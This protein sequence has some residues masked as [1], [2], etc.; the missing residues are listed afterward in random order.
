MKQFW[1]VL[2]IAG[3]ISV[4]AFGCGRVNWS[5]DDE[6]GFFVYRET[7]GP[8]SAAGG[9]D[10][11]QWIE[12]RRFMQVAFEPGYS[13]TAFAPSV[14]VDS[15]QVDVF[16]E[17]WTNKSG[18]SMLGSVQLFNPFRATNAINTSAE[19]DSFTKVIDFSSGKS[20]SLGYSAYTAGTGSWDSTRVD[21]V[22]MKNILNDQMWP[23]VRFR[24]VDT[25]TKMGKNYTMKLVVISR[26]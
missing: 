16:V 23:W 19:S 22:H 2:A 25:D 24:I 13:A 20:T 8:I 12:G 3:A 21:L 15:N 18:G 5:A 10:T 1:I 14:S 26:D 9:A 7:L 6:S 17:G 11:S 4:L